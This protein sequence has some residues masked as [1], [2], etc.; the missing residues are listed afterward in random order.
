MDS[1]RIAKE[2]DLKTIVDIYNQAVRS[3]FETA[4]TEEV[5]IK[6]RYVWFN[7]HKSDT[8]PI[9]VYEKDNEVVGWISVSPYRE[10]RKALKY[11]VEISYYIHN[12]YKRQG[13]GS[14]LV[15]YVIGKCNDLEYKS[16]FSIILDKNEASI[17]LMEKYGFEKW[18]HMPNIADFN[19]V[20]CG[21]VYYGLRITNNE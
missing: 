8:Y 7:K 14:E 9:F 21:H 12:D 17:R 3:G 18:A 2:D 13:V 5:D 20:E 1:I 11:T 15:K 6:D 16:L 19:G 10:G 4:D